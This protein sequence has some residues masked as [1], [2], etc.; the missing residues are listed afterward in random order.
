[1]PDRALA[2]TKSRSFPRDQVTLWC[3][4]KAVIETSKMVSL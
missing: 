2:K 3:F 1:L 4:G